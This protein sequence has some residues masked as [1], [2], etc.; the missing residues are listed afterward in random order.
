M[1]RESFHVRPWFAVDIVDIKRGDTEDI[2]SFSAVWVPAPLDV[3]PSIK[4]SY[5]PKMLIVDIHHSEIPKCWPCKLWSNS[6]FTSVVPWKCFWPLFVQMF[7]EIMFSAQKH[8]FLGQEFM[9]L[10]A[11]PKRISSI[12]NISNKEYLMKTIL[13]MMRIGSRKKT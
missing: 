8:P 1:T 7:K 2:R 10:L 3:I 13:S 4:S 12:C 11:R 6:S 5:T 9:R